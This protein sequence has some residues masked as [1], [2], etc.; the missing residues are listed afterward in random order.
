MRS[1]SS[2]PNPFDWVDNQFSDDDDYIFA[3]VTSSEDAAEESIIDEA[4]LEEVYGR[5]PE[6]KRRR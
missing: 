2:S 3:S 5:T 4:N 1:R 6:I